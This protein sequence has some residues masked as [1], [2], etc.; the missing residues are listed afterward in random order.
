VRAEAGVWKNI[1]RFGIWSLVG[2]FA[3]AYGHSKGNYLFFAGY[4]LVSAIIYIVDCLRAPMRR[5]MR[6]KGAGE[7]YGF[8]SRSDTGQCP[9][10]GRS[11]RQP[12]VGTWLLKLPRH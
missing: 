10:C 12:R 7:R 1:K 9:G 4:L 11:G 6:C 5:C 3:F 8:F 2:L